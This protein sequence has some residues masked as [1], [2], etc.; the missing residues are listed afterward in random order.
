MDFFFFNIALK[1]RVISERCYYTIPKFELLDIRSFYY[2][3]W[4]ISIINYF[5]VQETWFSN[6]TAISGH[7]IT[8]HSE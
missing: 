6:I 3:I 8:L 4:I 7:A 1:T 2:F 5:K